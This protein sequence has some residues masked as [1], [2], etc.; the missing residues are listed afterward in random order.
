MTVFDP[1][2]LGIWFYELKATVVF[3]CVVDL[4]YT[5][6][7]YIQY[8]HCNFPGKLFFHLHL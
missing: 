5:G 6:G 3:V 1:L 7:V 4:E 2:F 8:I